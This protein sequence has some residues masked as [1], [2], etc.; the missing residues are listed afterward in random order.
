MSNPLTVDFRQINIYQ[1]ESLIL[2]NTDLQIAKGEF[3]YLIG[4]VGT[5][6]TTLLK[7]INA[8]VSVRN[9]YASV[10]G[11][12]M[13]NLKQSQIPLLRRKIGMVFQDFKLLTDRTVYNNLL[14]VL[15]ATGWR[16]DSLIR[17][18]IN[19]VL[20]AVGMKQQAERMPHQL[21]G[22][23][24]QRV[25]ISRALLNNPDLILADEPT[26]NLDPESSDEIMKILQTISTQYHSAVLMATHNRYVLDKYPARTLKCE[27]EGLTLL[28]AIEETNFDLLEF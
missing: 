26:G 22:G 27:K 20:D 23:E 4:K 8:E 17:E 19:Q 5:G 28:N 15:K 1:D 7:A 24:Q 3:V 10:A 25:A 11:F 13:L 2:L 12:N 14:F 6:K 21:S 9:G 18:R 16:D